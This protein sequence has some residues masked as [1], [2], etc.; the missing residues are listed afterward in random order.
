MEIHIKTRIVSFIVISVLCLL[1]AK[2]F[3]FDDTIP[4]FQIQKWNK[5]KA[6]PPRTFS[7]TLQFKPPVPARE[8]FVAGSFNG[9]S[10]RDIKMQGPNENGIYQV[11]LHLTE[12]TYQYKFVVNGDHWFQDPSNPNKEDDGHN[13]YNSIIN[14]SPIPSLPSGLQRGDGRIFKNGVDYYP[15]FP[16]LERISENQVKFIIQTGKDDLTHVNIIT[17]NP[18][19]KSWQPSVHPMILFYSTKNWDYFETKVSLNTETCGYYFQLTDKTTTIYAG[20]NGLQSSVNKVES[21][22]LVISELT[23]FKTPLW[24]KKAVWY[25]IFPER[26]RNGD[27]TND[28]LGNHTPPWTSDWF[29]LLPWEHGNFYANVYNRFYGGDLQGVLQELPYLKKLGITA[30]YF[31]PVF[32]SPSIHGYDTMDYRHIN[33]HFGYL[34]DTVTPPGETLD[35]KT[36]KLTTLS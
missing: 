36:W 15:A 31:N 1:T 35:P 26:F 32:M 23:Y 10:P 28:I 4:I 2:G 24:A 11:T 3:P 5:I 27:T 14:I 25:Q 18:F 17:F 13:G 9:W 7:T 12:D 20:M 22:P 16:D 21:Y 8:V 6:L 30:I 34:Q 33:P 19:L 29:K